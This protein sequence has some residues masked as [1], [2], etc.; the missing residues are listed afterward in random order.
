MTASA[1]LL[2][3]SRYFRLWSIG[4][5]CG[6]VRWL[7]LLAF[8]VYAFDVTGSPALVALVVM[9]RFLPLSLFGVFMGALSDIVSPER[10]MTGA[11]AAIMCVSIA[12]FAAFRLAEPGYWL[13][14]GAAFASG[15]FWATDLPIRRKILASHAPPGRLAGAMALDG[16]TSNG[17]RMLGPLVGG[18]L[19][20]ALG[21][22]G[23]FALGAV[24][25]AGALVIALTLPA[26]P[27]A[28][29]SDPA[30]PLRRALRGAKEAWAYA[31]R[32]GDVM[33]ILW[34]TVVFNIWGFP[35][36]AMI[37]VI[38]RED[39]SLTASMIGGITAVE[40]AFA[41]FGALLL[42][43]TV[44]ERWFRPIYWGGTM[45]L[46]LVIFA[47]GLLPG[48]W[49][50]TLGLALG[51]LCAAGFAVMQSTLIYHAAPPEMRGRFLGLM[52]ICIGAGVI[53]FA[54]VGLTA[55][56]FGAA[57]ALWIIALE[58]V[59]PML[60]ILRGWRANVT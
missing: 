45:L 7:E 1:R 32:N 13:V 14:A 50:L 25:Y 41:L 42:T 33:R 51:G 46:I 57:D 26:T 5:L 44:A 36:L 9:L 56:V 28:E 18:A 60:L 27:P 22:D 48:F 16:A 34:V 38:G 19:Y 59:I 20:Q 29:T 43:R 3:D 47:I 8:G 58:G 2:A 15:V 52:T 49:T 37:P 24:L 39:L 11:I 23:V 4:L 40:G 6:I 17:T 55:E 31:R 35:Y 10:L 30:R 21:V 53:G 54:N 12:V